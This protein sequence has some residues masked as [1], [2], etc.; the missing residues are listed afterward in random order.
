MCDREEGVREKRV[1]KGREFKREELVREE[2]TCGKSLRR[3]KER[4]SEKERV[5]GEKPVR[6][7]RE[8]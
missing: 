6:G 8:C 7:K 3:E 4:E 1:I 5:R 2:R